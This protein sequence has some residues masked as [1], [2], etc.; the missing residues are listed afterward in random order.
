[1]KNLVI[2]DLGSNSVRMKICQI[3][4]YGS[5][6]IVS[7]HKEYVRLSENMGPEKTLKTEPIERTIQ[8]LKDFKQEYDQFDNIEIRAVATAAVRQAKNQQEFLD[9]VKKEIDLELRVISGE[10]GLDSE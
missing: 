5:F 4:E 10:T 2:I 6:E 1:M 3:D 8:A 9:L 7:Y